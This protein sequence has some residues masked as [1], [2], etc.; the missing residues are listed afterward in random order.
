M[1]DIIHLA[2]IRAPG[3]FPGQVSAWW[4]QRVMVPCASLPSSACS[5]STARPRTSHSGGMYTVGD[6]AKATDRT[7]PAP[8]PVVKHRPHVTECLPRAGTQQE[9]LRR[10]K[11][12][13]GDT[14]ESESPQMA[15]NVLPKAELGLLTPRLGQLRQAASSP[16]G[17]FQGIPEKIAPRSWGCHSEVQWDLPV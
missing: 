16:E 3:A 13:R 10:E 11:A 15:E 12:R 6:S 9:G 2:P 1:V 17:A 4:G 5:E 8:G 7:S 14:A